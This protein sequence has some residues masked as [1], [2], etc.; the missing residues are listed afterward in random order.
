MAK[1]E[2]IRHFFCIQKKRE[3]STRAIRIRFNN[4]RDR[5]E[6]KPVSKN[7]KRGFHV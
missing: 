2:R 3:L 4:I 5:N 7:I 1:F 6:E